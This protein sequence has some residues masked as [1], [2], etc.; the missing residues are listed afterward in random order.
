M[1]GCRPLRGLDGVFMLTD[2]GAC[3]PGFMLTP[4]SQAKTVDRR[5][6]TLLRGAQEGSESEKIC[7]DASGGYF[8]SG[9]RTS[10]NHW[11][12]VI[13][14]GL[15]AHYVVTAGEACERVIERIPAHL[16]GHLASAIYCSDV[17]HHLPLLAG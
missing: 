4:A 17:A 16:S 11:L 13:A 15:E 2:P 14:G 9:A 12:S 7:E 8:W 10:D 6:R 5:L 1:I 3:A